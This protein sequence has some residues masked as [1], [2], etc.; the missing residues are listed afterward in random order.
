MTGSSQADWGIRLARYP[1]QPLRLLGGKTV[2]EYLFVIT[3]SFSLV[4]AWL[5]AIIE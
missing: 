4:G 5:Y 2:Y 3:I 1:G